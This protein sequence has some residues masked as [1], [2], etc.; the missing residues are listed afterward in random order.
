MS[1]LVPPTIS[2]EAWAMRAH[3]DGLDLCNKLFVLPTTFICLSFCNIHLIYIIEYIALY[4]I[5][6]NLKSKQAGSE[7]IVL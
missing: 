4:Y 3:V 6:Y 5:F 2:V 7:N 1:E